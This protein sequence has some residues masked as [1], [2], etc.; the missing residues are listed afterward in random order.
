[1]RMIITNVRMI[2]S[3]IF[4]HIYLSLVKTI[5][6]NVNSFDEITP[7]ES[8]QPTSTN[9]RFRID[10]DILEVEGNFIKKH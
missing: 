10:H 3:E 9:S 1:M 4:K 7:M 2:E 5:E 8:D 6:D